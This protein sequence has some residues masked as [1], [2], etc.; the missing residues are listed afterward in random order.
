MMTKVEFKE[1]LEK[2]NPASTQQFTEALSMSEKVLKL[3]DREFS[4][5]IRLSLPTVRR[6]RAGTF[7]PHESIR[8]GVI[9]FLIELC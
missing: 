6:W 2:V 9:K 5:K 8:P 4:K 7:A 3:S 1:Y